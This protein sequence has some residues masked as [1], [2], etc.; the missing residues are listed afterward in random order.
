MLGECYFLFIVNNKPDAAFTA[1]EIIIKWLVGGEKKQQT[2]NQVSSNSIVCL[3]TRLSVQTVSMGVE[4]FKTGERVSGDIAVNQCAAPLPGNYLAHF[5]EHNWDK[6]AV[7]HSAIL[8]AVSIR[9][10]W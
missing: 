3:T 8:C 2:G 9:V 1:N 4:P 5:C 10:R 7:C 6:S